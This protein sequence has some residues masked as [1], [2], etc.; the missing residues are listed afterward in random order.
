MGIQS[1]TGGRET[2]GAPPA[3]GRRAATAAMLLAVTAD[4]QAAQT[5]HVSKDLLK[6]TGD[7]E[8]AAAP[9]DSSKA[10]D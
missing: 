5:V 8:D 10:E 6:T 1:R 4:E 9:S 2:S 3:K 7:R